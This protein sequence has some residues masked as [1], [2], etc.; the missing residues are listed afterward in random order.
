MYTSGHAS[1]KDLQKVRDL[2]R[3]VARGPRHHDQLI[4][5]ALYYM[6]PLHEEDKALQLMEEVVTRV[7]DCWLARVWAA[8]LYLHHRMD[9]ISLLRAQDLLRPLTDQKGN[10]SAAAWL[11]LAQIGRELEQLDPAGVAENLERSVEEAPSWV[12]NH[13][14]LASCYRILGR[15]SDALRE[16]DLAEDNV[17]PV[18][19]SVSK[20]DLEFDSAITART[21]H[22]IL[23]LLESARNKL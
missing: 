21:S 18:D 6:E 13:Y 22:G 2:E 17:H 15:T 3:A 11:L 1:K 5:L 19:Y 10:A 12:L 8:Y 20:A 7:P 23:D 14:L 16:L 4:E 9:R